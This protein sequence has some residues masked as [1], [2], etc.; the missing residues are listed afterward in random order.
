M[1]FT[2]YAFLF[3][4]LPASLAVFFV[5]GKYSPRWAALSLFVASLIFYAYWNPK[6][7]ALLLASIIFNFVIAR[8]IYR[9]R[10]AIA[11]KWHNNLLWLGVAA[12]LLLLGYFKYTNFF[13]SNVDAALGTQ[14]NLQHIVLPLGISFFTFTQ[15]AFL[16]DVARGKAH[17]FNII[18]YGLFVSYFPHLLAGPILHHSEMMPQ[19]A[20]KSVY[21][22]DPANIAI[23]LTMFGIGL[24]K[25]LVFADSLIP[26]ITPVYGS[27]LT[28]HTLPPDLVSAW[29]AT[30]AYTLQLYFDFSGYSDMAIG[31]SRLFGIKLPLNFASPYKSA[32][33]IDFWRRWHMTLSR[34]LKDYLYISLGGNKR[35]K[36]RRYINLMATMV[37]GGLWHGANW[38]FIVWGALHGFYLIINHAW[39]AIAKR[40]Q[41]GR[42]ATIAGRIAGFLLT[43]I[44]VM[45]GWVFFRANDI[46]SAASV[47]RGMF[48]FGIPGFSVFQ[49]DAQK[50]MDLA[51]YYWAIDT[52]V[53]G[54]S[55]AGIFAFL[56][57]FFSSV[58]LGIIGNSAWMAILLAVVWC[59]PNSQ[60]IMGRFEIALYQTSGAINR[61][62]QWRPTAAW[63]VVLGVALF[64]VLMH[65]SSLPVTEF[66]YFNF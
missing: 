11:G 22:I 30:I 61:W 15:I 56:V 38:T 4:F 64:A 42:G 32:N 50:F 9:S 34:F 33:I 12:N 60:E 19:F 31:L 14:F 16:A 25:K 23:G 37:L 44:A 58:P 5:I 49:A 65:L 29:L 51:N 6:F 1:L 52:S 21:K 53:A 59:A 46:S 63:G 18:H 20:Q 2:S 45:V 55:M 47:L 54:S 36:G 10:S 27:S 28:A 43:F 62:W 24:I 57:D 26:M 3:L 8:A 39:Q 7:V 17:E 41:F 40:L 66:L 48:G 35:G 13:L